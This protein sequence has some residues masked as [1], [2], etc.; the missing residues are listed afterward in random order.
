MPALIVGA[1]GLAVCALAWRLGAS[2]ES[3]QQLF[4]SY[5]YAYMFWVGIPLGCLAILMLQHLTGGAWGLAI[6]R[7]LETGTR[8]LP[9][10]AI[11]F[12]PLIFGMRDLYDWTRDEHLHGL[13]A[14]WLTVDGFIWRAAAYF[15]I[16]LVLAFFLNKWSK[17]QDRGENP[18]L[19][20]RMQLIS[21]PGLLLYGFTVT[22]AAVDWVMSLEYHWYSTIYG[23]LF[24][25]GQA[26]GTLALM[27]ALLALLSRRHPLSD[28]VTINHF[29]D[30]GNLLLAFVL[31]W[32]YISF[33]QYLIIWSANIAEETPYYVQRAQA[34]SWK[35]IALILIIFH[36]FVPFLLL[37]SRRTKR[38][39]SALV[40]VALIIVASRFVDLFWLISPAVEYHAHAGAVEFHGFRLHWLDVLAPIAI[41]GIWV[42][43]FIMQLQRRPLVP[44]HDPR[45][46]EVHHH[47]G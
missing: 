15:L 47:H 19:A 26:L 11:L 9:L 42:A 23:M 18:R 13:K 20:R 36:F 22:F 3:R 12:L 8:M 27:I 7:L 24:I 40:T 43:Y 45:L 28:V 25:V 33:S 1:A 14:H 31:L 41:G 32:A 16:W 39:V 46:Q 38:S 21:G 4:V 37:L 34:T 2:P 44:P 10:M 5:L 6:R 35:Y 29:N 30:L 17:D